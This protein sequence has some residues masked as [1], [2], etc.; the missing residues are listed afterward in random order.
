MNKPLRSPFAAHP[1]TPAAHG[2]QTSAQALAA[3]HA[4]N[5]VQLRANP[6]RPSV[7]KPAAPPAYRPQP[8][9]GVLQ[10]KAQGGSHAPGRDVR[11][12]P[13]A[14]PVYKPQPP[15][16]VLQ[17]KSRLPA[18]LAPAQPARTPHA[19]PQAYRPQTPP[20]A[21][22]VQNAFGQPRP[23]QVAPLARR[24]GVPTP[25]PHAGARSGVGSVQPKMAAAPHAAQAH[26]PHR[27]HPP[28]QP[29]SPRQA[30][31]TP[32]PVVQRQARPTASQ[33][34]QRVR[35]PDTHDL[36]NARRYVQWRTYKNDPQ[37]SQGG[38]HRLGQCYICG[39]YDF[40]NVMEVDH[41]V[42]E[43]FM[44]SLLNLRGENQGMAE[45]I[46]EALQLDWKK[47]REYDYEATY[48]AYPSFRDRYD[49]VDRTS[50][51]AFNG[52]LYEALADVDNLRLICSSCN[53]KKVKSNRL[54]K[55]D[56]DALKVEYKKWNKSGRQ[57]IKKHLGA[58]IKT[59]YYIDHT[60]VGADYGSPPNSPGHP[61]ANNFTL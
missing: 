7:A 31:L 52:N 1:A 19:A 51:H 20:Q 44:R 43:D 18:G 12:V 49:N 16:Q 30:Q 35:I 41:V 46:A 42:P 9:P 45:D 22:P 15:P 5:A 36:K 61:A 37:V 25:P 13:A 50:K 60:T 10:Q 21:S 59:N 58:W 32:S 39:K 47:T 34:I 14:P 54:L 53:G 33:T 24:P 17:G 40:M 57:L 28:A 8:A 55:I 38:Q 23:P 3:A 27:P 11:S 2:R 29:P 26:H 56:Y 48:N 6:E 4:R